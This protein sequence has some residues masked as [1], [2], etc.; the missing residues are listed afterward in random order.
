MMRYFRFYLILV[1][2]LS[3]L[4]AEE[5]LI[6]AHRG[7]SKDAPEN[8]LP[9]FQLAWQQGADAIEGDFHLTKDGHIVCIHDANTKKTAG[10]DL[11][12]KNTTLEELQ[13]LDV[14]SYHSVKY[15]GTRMPTLSEVMAT[16]PEGKKIYIEIKCGRSI[17]P[18][19]L[20]EIGDSNLEQ[21]QIVVISF[22]DDVIQTLEATAPQHKSCLLV[23]LKKDKTGAFSPPLISVVSRLHET[24]ADGLSA[25]YSHLSEFII[26][27]VKG[28]GCECHTWTV[29][30]PISALK[31]KDWGIQSITT[32]KP[33]LIR[34]HLKR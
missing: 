34:R 14:G 29:D 15:K 2:A 27:T 32:N 23:S 31:L 24:R 33:G 12:V 11:A 3:Q 25:S 30:D 7:A 19:L 4:G 16:V 28:E 21:D 6:V 10:V 8:T 1:V 22:N 13:K 9:A 17:V 5:P 26:R 18:S 20:R